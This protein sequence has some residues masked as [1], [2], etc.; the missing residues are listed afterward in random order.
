MCRCP[1]PDAS[2]GQHTEPLQLQSDASLKVKQKAERSCFSEGCCPSTSTVCSRCMARRQCTATASAC[3]CMSHQ[4][5]SWRHPNSIPEQRPA[6]G[7][8]PP[9]ATCRAAAAALAPVVEQ[10]GWGGQALGTLSRLKNGCSN[11]AGGVGASRWH[12]SY[13]QR[14]T[15]TL[16]AQTD[17]RRLTCR[18]GMLTRPLKVSRSTK[19][20][21]HTWQE[22]GGKG[23][24]KKLRRMRHLLLS[25]IEIRKPE[26]GK[27]F[28]PPCPPANLGSHSAAAACTAAG[29]AHLHMYRQVRLTRQAAI[30][31]QLKR[32]VKHGVGAVAEGHLQARQESS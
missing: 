6:P 14:E 17:G 23:Q 9:A 13:T 2:H 25:R 15:A 7:A 21:T 10:C 18:S 27:V 1:H 31:H 22:Q 29:A 20:C 3:T 28:A 4:Q 12:L 11:C 26:S 16:L 24:A 8:P 32:F 19:C 30:Q 5:A